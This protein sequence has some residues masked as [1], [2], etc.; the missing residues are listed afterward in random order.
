[1]GSFFLSLR[2]LHIPCCANMT[3]EMLQCTREIFL[4]TPLVWMGK[5]EFNAYLI[6]NTLICKNKSVPP[7]AGQVVND[8]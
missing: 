2:V 3:D 6:L 4:E 7:C 8:T 1:M 5:G